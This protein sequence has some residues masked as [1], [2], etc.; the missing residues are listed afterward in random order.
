MKMEVRKVH[1]RVA[2][3]IS[4]EKCCSATT[5]FSFCTLL[6]WENSLGNSIPRPEAQT[7]LQWTVCYT[8]EIKGALIE[9][10]KGKAEKNKYEEKYISF[11]S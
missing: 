4:A 10:M 11:G 6:L 8:G 7:D 5:F 2:H 1:N 3:L 9:Q